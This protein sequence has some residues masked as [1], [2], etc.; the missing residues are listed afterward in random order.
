VTASAHGDR[1]RIVVEDTGQ[2][3]AAGDLPKLFSP[4]ERLGA[5]ATHVTG[6]GLGLAVSRSLCDGMGGVLD[7]V[8]AVGEGSTFAVDLPVAS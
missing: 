1:G 5:E 8:S 3:I 4:F 7:A 2:G 6:T